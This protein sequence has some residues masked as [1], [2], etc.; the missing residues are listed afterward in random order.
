MSIEILKFKTQA[1]D[2]YNPSRRRN[3]SIA[4]DEMIVDMISNKKLNQIVTELFIR[5]RRLN[6][7]S[8]FIT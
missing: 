7:T 5:E 8:G 3:V 6:V 1:E 4:F 2:V